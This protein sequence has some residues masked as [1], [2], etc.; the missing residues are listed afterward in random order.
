MKVI[1]SF[2]SLVLGELQCYNFRCTANNYFDIE[3]KMSIH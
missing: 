3:Y 2:D 1:H